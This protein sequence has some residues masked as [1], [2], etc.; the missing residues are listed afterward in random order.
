MAWV[1]SCAMMLEFFLMALPALAAGAAMRQ[2]SLRTARLD[3]DHDATGYGPGKCVGVQRSKGGTC[4]LSTHCKEDDDLETVEF[5]FL[6]V[7]GNGEVQKHSYGKGGFDPDESFDSSI[8]CAQCLLPTTALHLK[9]HQTS[10]E[11]S[12]DEKEA[13]PAPAP[14]PA[15]AP[16]KAAAPAKKA[17]ASN[18]T[19]PAIKK[20]PVDLHTKG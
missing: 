10:S 15:P 5:A 16:E 13:Q 7:L 2:K 8:S 11:Q 12:S 20:L 4:V 3:S 17:N 14:A 9:H 1:W 19:A 18:A 6:C